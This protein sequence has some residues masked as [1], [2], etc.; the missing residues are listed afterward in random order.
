MYTLL[1]YLNDCAPSGGT[2]FY[3][4]AAK[5]SL[6]TDVDGRFVGRSETEM[7]TV[8]AV[9][10]RALIFYHNHMHEGTSPTPGTCK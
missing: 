10:G 3:S 5:G 7:L 9:K 4:D 6:I 8:S 1:V 2:K